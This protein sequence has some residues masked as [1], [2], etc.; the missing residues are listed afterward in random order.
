[1]NIL[2]NLKIEKISTDNTIKYNTNCFPDRTAKL[3]DIEACREIRTLGIHP[4]N[5]HLVKF[6]P[7]SNYVFTFS[8]FEA[9]AW[10]YRTPECICVKVLNSSGQVNEGEFL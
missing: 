7:F 8:M 6:V 9:R 2:E 1:M 10:D 3:W 5:V 4:N